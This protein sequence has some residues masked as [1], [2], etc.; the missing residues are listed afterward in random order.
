MG[1]QHANYLTAAVGHG[2]V[3][4]GRK[5]TQVWLLWNSKKTFSRNYAF[6]VKIHWLLLVKEAFVLT[7]GLFWEPWDSSN[8]F[9]KG[10]RLQ[11]YDIEV[12]TPFHWKANTA[13]ARC[14]KAAF[15][16]IQVLCQIKGQMEITQGLTSAR[17]IQLHL[18]PDQ[19]KQLSSASSTNAQNTSCY[20]VIII[21]I[22]RHNI[23][24]ISST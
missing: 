4:H 1:S 22:N 13:T 21:D 20:C 10:I 16:S 7:A 8:V 5:Q 15:S 17:G 18:F 3:F 14:E 12:G 6:T 24:D 2:S 19:S 23:T 9:W 11:N